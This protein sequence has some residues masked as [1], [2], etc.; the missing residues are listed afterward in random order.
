MPSLVGMPS[1]IGRYIICIFL[2]G[3]CF[4]MSLVLLYCLYIF[5]KIK[6]LL[7]YKKRFPWVVKVECYMCLIQC[8]II[9]PLWILCASEFTT[10]TKSTYTDNLNLIFFL[11]YLIYPFFGHAVTCLEA[12]RLWI[13]YYKMNH[14]NAVSNNQWESV[15]DNTSMMHNWYL[16]HSTTFGCLRWVM[17]RVFVYYIFVSI[18]SMVLLVHFGFT[19]HTQCVDCFFYSVPILFILYLYT[20]LLRKKQI[21]DNFLFYLEFKTTNRIFMI[22][23]SL[24]AFAPLMF[25]L[26]PYYADM[27]TAM[28]GVTILTGP[29]VISALYIPRMILQNIL[30]SDVTPHRKKLND[31]VS[32]GSSVASL[33]PPCPSDTKSPSNSTISYVV[34][35]VYAESHKRVYLDEIFVNKV[36]TQY[37]IHHVIKEFSLECVLSWIEMKQFGYYLYTQLKA[38]DVNLSTDPTINRDIEPLAQHVPQSTIVYCT[39]INDRK[40]KV[41]HNFKDKFVALYDKY[42]E[43]K[44]EY[45]VNISYELKERLDC[46]KSMHESDAWN[47]NEKELL[48]VF[49]EVIAEMRIFMNTSLQRF[50]K[51]V[52][53]K[54]IYQN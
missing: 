41:M 46:F 21:H 28:L 20:T 23:L 27:W 9:W 4:M 38:L 16:M 3:C 26:D 30:W 32:P 7:I 42:I 48:G 11:N 35:E 25:A 1:E 52:E 53:W 2:C 13:M 24:Y 14:M 31:V 17:K 54:Q 50:T 19:A 22:G 34:S 8:S 10:L 12:V 29:T 33:S 51:S 43:D 6:V 45:E 40:E 49:H 44:A 18:S 15:I 47:V 5:N 37:F 36:Y 39:E